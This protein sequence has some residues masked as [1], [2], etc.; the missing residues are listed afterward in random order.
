MR[1]RKEAPTFSRQSENCDPQGGA[2]RNARRKEVLMKKG[3]SER[4]TLKLS[5]GITMEMVDDKE[6]DLI[7]T[8]CSRRPT[9][10][11]RFNPAFNREYWPRANETIDKILRDKPTRR[12][13]ASQQRKKKKDC[14]PR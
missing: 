10:E 2:G 6:N 5:C 3:K 7:I 1:I 13:A 12:R 11:Q 14:A 4:Y 9:D 8:Y